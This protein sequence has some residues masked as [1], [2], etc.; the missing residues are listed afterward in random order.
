MRLIHDGLFQLYRHLGVGEVDYD[1]QESDDK[2]TITMPLPGLNKDHL[3]IKIQN[4]SKL[5]VKNGKGTRFIPEFTYSFIIPD[6][7]D[8]FA[9]LEDGILTMEIMKRKKYEKKII[10]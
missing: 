9:K 2:I 10:L 6:S 4:N 8:V 5:V 1:L 3:E 7:D